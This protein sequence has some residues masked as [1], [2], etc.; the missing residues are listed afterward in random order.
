M[1]SISGKKYLNDV[2]VDTISVVVQDGT[3]GG[4]TLIHDVDVF[5]DVVKVELYF[6]DSSIRVKRPTSVSAKSPTRLVRSGNRLSE[7]TWDDF[8]HA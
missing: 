4:W 7:R 5:A 2:L 3:Q 6:D 1:T 8:E